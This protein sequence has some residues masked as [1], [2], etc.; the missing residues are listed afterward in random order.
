MGLLTLVLVC[1]LNL[2]LLCLRYPNMRLDVRAGDVLAENVVYPFSGIDAYRTD[3]LRQAARDR[4]QPVYRLDEAVVTA[5]EAALDRWFAQYDLFLKDMTERWEQSAQEHN[6]YLYNQTAW[7]ALVKETELRS[8]LSEY[9]LSDVLDTVMA[10]SLLDTYMPRSSLHAAGSVPDTSPVRTAISEAI[11]T[12]MRSG[13][14]ESELESARYGARE[15]LKQTSLP[16]VSKT[17]LAG[18]LIDKFFVASAVVDQVETEKARAAAADG[19][20]PATVKRGELLL[21][22]GTTL[23]QKDIVHL[24]ALDMLRTGEDRG[25]WGSFLLYLLPIYLV[26]ALYLLLFE[27]ETALSPMAMVR[28][29]L[30]LILSLT[31]S[32]VFTIFESRIAPV[33]LAVFMIAAT[34]EKRTALSASVLIA[35]TASL[36]LP[37]SG[38]MAGE[39]FA[40]MAGVLLAGVTSA[41]LMTVDTRRTAMVPAAIIGGAIGALMP[42]VPKL[43][44]GEGLLVSVTAFGLFFLGAIIAMVLGMGLTVIWEIVFDLPSPAKLNELLNMDHPLQRR[45]MNHA[46]GTYHHCQMTALLAESGAQSIGADALLVKAAAAVHD[47]GKLRGPRFFSEN[48]ANGINPHDDL[49]PRESAQIIISHVPNG[50]AIL[51][52]YRVPAAVRSIVREHHGTTMTAYFYVKAK[53]SDPDAQEADFRYPGPRPS[54]RESAVLMLADSCEAAVR[55]LGG[56]SPEQ[57]R[58]MV[59]QVI[60]GKMEEGQL[61]NSE[62]TLNEINRVEEAFLQTFTGILH[63]RIAYPKEEA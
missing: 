43:L 41:G 20:S 6:G 57:V 2:F 21:R 54:S 29:S 25:P 9:G 51:R 33:L 59:R 12:G 27:R 28:L 19:V 63:D 3:E 60:R 17:E 47:A 4:V 13:V 16:A 40:Y 38:L 42:A 49:P 8:K 34:H 7:N 36:L 1:L 55:S 14:K 11:L 58:D 45:L 52:R 56:P 46:P 24:V 10:Y 61:M 5:Q 31:V 30:L 15:Q 48:Q 23:T 50:D 26:Y 18:N 35:L 44:G 53:K 22:K 37:S 32:W 62:L 39:T